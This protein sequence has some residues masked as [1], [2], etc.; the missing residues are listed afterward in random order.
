MN[1]LYALFNFSPSIQVDQKPNPR[2][3][4]NTNL[5]ARPLPLQ[6]HPLPPYSPSNPL[7]LLHLLYHLLLPYFKTL[8][9][10]PQIHK[11]YYSP[12]TRSIHVTNPESVRALWEQGFFGKGSLS[13]SE[14]E[15]M[16]R[17]RKRREGE[18]G[19]T[20]GEVTR[21]RREE[22]RKVKRE[23]ARV[24]REE[25]EATLRAEGKLGVDVREVDGADVNEG[26]EGANGDAV[27]IDAS[28]KTRAADAPEIASPV[29]STANAA[30]PP[31][32][33]QNQE[34]LQL[35]PHEA[36]Y[37][38][39]TLGVLDIY[40]P[41]SNILPQTTTA[42]N[43]PTIP[44]SNT[45]HDT[46]K[47]IHKSD[48]PLSTTD[49]L[50]L[51]RRTSIFPPLTSSDPTPPDDSFI[52]SY[53]VY[54]HFRTL[55][56]VVRPGQKFACDF[57]L[58][59]RGPVFAHAEFAVVILPSYSRWSNERSESDES[60]EHDEH[61][62]H[63]ECDTCCKSK[64]GG[65]PHESPS[66]TPRQDETH[67][68]N[69]T[70]QNEQHARNQESTQVPSAITSNALRDDATAKPRRHV[71]QGEI[72]KRKWGERGEWWHLHALSRV[73]TQ[74]MK[75]LVLCYVDIP[76]PEEV[77]EV[78]QEDVG[79]LLRLYHVR[80]FVVRRWVMNRSRD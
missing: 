6:I 65:E 18:N 39:Y 47:P 45:F 59:A 66:S 78:G 10:H 15:W 51:L 27:A 46:H 19:R 43:T 60:D 34:H 12:L 38:K 30:T 2:R 80:E 62:E 5:Y 72:E 52:T 40:P 32:I 35:T 55:G 11:S 24:E 44:T 49:F 4:Q 75:S 13:R 29:E 41:P 58:Y 79:G 28:I 17:E 57:L 69:N 36:L 50:R 68:A 33:L 67:D 73:Q 56:W 20:A 48:K 16:E 9:S 26:V 31:P 71:K 77:D 3:P 37:L 61:D 14:P 64:A 53:I 74:V 21:R 25:L 23:R 54:H 1:R 8:T 70:S 76:T 7:S 63:D 22:R 42:D